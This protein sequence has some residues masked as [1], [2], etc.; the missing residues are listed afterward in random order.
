MIASGHYMFQDKTQDI[1]QYF[2]IWMVLG[3]FLTPSPHAVLT[4]DESLRVEAQD[5]SKTIEELMEVLRNIYGPSIP[6]ATGTNIA[7]SVEEQF[8]HFLILSVK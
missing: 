2:S 4:G 1:S 6:N 8:Y 7:D 3:S 5:D